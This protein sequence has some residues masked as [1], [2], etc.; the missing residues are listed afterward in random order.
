MTVRDTIFWSST[1]CEHGDYAVEQIYAI[2]MV[3]HVSTRF[4]YLFFYN[5]FFIFFYENRFYHIVFLN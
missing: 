3:Y 2:F 1:R 4:I 5:F